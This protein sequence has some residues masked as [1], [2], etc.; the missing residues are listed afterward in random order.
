MKIL[1]AVLAHK[2]FEWNDLSQ[3]DLA[4]FL[5]ITP[6]DIKTNLPNV[7]KYEE[8]DGY[9]NRIYSELSQHK[10]I[11]EKINFDWI[12]INHYR[13]RFDLPD[14]Q[15]VYVPTPVTFNDKIKN[16]YGIFH[17]GPDLDL[18]TDI[19][20][21]SELEDS[22]KMEWLKSLNDDKMICYNMMSG[23]KE[24]Y[25]DLID[26]CFMLL[27][28]FKKL[29][30]FTNYDKVVKFY[31]KV[32]KE[33]DENN[34]KVDTHEPFRVFGF[35]NERL[36]NCYFRWYSNKHN[37]IMNLNNPVS[38]CKVKLLEDGMII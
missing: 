15:N 24:L 3:D 1:N 32:N 23:P 26:T 6:N 18:M 13:R 34:L 27:D 30:R 4:K 17:Y 12:V 33:K 29:R 38:P 10:Y 36:T 14:Y 21:D 31:T 5:V 37:N 8:I 11:R 16:L 2:D 20:M 28:R 25:Y 9:D 19:I 35:L 7:C 22:F